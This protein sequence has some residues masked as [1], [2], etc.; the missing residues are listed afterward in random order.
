MSF[1]SL[2]LAERFENLASVSKIQ[3]RL[4]VLSFYFYCAW[5]SCYNK[6]ITFIF[7]LKI[8]K[9]MEYF[10]IKIVSICEIHQQSILTHRKNNHVT[11]QWQLHK[12]KKFILHTVIVLHLK[13]FCQLYV[14]TSH[15]YI[16]CDKRKTRLEHLPF[17]YLK[18]CFSSAFP[19]KKNRSGLAEGLGSSIKTLVA[20][21]ADVL[22]CTACS[23]PPQSILS[24]QVEPR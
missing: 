6:K 7:P 16:Y 14:T 22:L 4:F 18:I 2:S 19:F 20:A 24:F 9:A 8:K 21:V 12:E 17:Y 23:F 3:E 11:Y 5:K 1:N 15:V 13:H 10:A